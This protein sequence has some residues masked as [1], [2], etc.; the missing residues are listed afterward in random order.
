MWSMCRSNYFIYEEMLES[1]KEYEDN[2][3]K[4]GDMSSL[5]TRT[6]GGRQGS[7]WCIWSSV[8]LFKEMIFGLC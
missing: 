7:P 2:L 8:S 5:S 1:T 4:Q 6:H 3:A